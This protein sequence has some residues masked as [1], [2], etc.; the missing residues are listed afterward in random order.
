MTE[1]VPSPGL[2]SANSLMIAEPSVAPG[3]MSEWGIDGLFPIT[4]ATAMLSPSA[5]P[6]ASVIAVWIPARA[7]GR[8]ALL[9]TCHRVAPSA[10]AASRSA[11]GTLAIAVRL[12]A[13]MVGN[14]ITART[15]EARRTLG[16]YAT[17]RKNHPIAGIERRDGSTSRANT[18]EST[19]NPQSP[20]TMLG[21]AARSSIAAESGAAIQRGAISAREIA[22]PSPIG[23]TIANDRAV[24]TTV[25]TTRRPAPYEL[26][27][28][29]H[30][31]D[32]RK[33]IPE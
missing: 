9:V 6:V 14:V 18:G 5:L 30:V 10:S 24:V 28:G 17:P 15:T 11:V 8:T 25:P 27:A 2:D 7:P 29:F 21:T 4:I 19:S 33:P 13:T 3:A 16:P 1:L 22:A 31:P 32:Q 12:R 23:I 26:A 20:T